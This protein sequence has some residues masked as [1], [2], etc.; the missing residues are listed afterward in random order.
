MEQYFK[1]I[2]YAVLFLIYIV[3]Q[4]RKMKKK[5]E[6]EKALQP[7]VLKEVVVKPVSKKVFDYK[8]KR[9]FKSKKKFA[10]FSQRHEEEDKPIVYK[11]VADEELI[12]E[13]QLIEKTL[14]D[15]RLEEQALKGE[16]KALEN[17]YLEPYTGQGRKQANDT[18]N[19][20]KNKSNLKKAF[21]ASEIFQKRY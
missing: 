21:I 20:L 4:V 8:G 6:E 3:S 18:A 19:W 9:E 14:Q 13:A 2:L 5:A 12:A 7:E 11:P 10:S 16:R 17:E 15:R 1:F